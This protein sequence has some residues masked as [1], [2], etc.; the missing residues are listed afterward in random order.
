MTSFIEY[1]L[2]LPCSSCS[3]RHAA[4]PSLLLLP[5]VIAD[6]FWRSPV[7][8]GA[9][10]ATGLL[11]SLRSTS[12]SLLICSSLPPMVARDAFHPARVL[13]W[14]CSSCY[15]VLVGGPCPRLQLR[16]VSSP[17]P[18]FIDAL[19]YLSVTWIGD[20]ILGSRFIDPLVYLSVTKVVDSLLSM[21]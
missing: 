9:M 15:V 16:L 8:Y 2:P 20:A 1:D 12:P 21:K 5:R 17:L 3:S 10:L 13:V 14:L 4:P 19:S 7:C 11:P 18:W 6:I